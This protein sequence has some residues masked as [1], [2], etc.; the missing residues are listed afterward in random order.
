MKRRLRENLKEA[1]DL[2]QRRM[3]LA[4]RSETGSGLGEAGEGGIERSLHRLMLL[5]DGC[6]HHRRRSRRSAPHEQ[7]SPARQGFG[8][9]R[10][11][12]GFAAKP[13]VIAVEPVAVAARDGDRF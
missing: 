6:D 2:S 1:E 3:R 7:R 9:L 5:N 8:F 13:I 10:R 11:S 4:N 12:A